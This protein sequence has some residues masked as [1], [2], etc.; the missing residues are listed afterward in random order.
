[1]PRCWLL[2]V[3]ALLPIACSKSGDPASVAETKS[4]DKKDVA[5]SNTPEERFSQ[6]FAQAVTIEIGEDQQVPPD[7]TTAGKPTGPLREAVEKLWPNIALTY[8]NGKLADD[9]RTVTL[10]TAEGNIEITLRPD[11][12]PNHVRN[13]LA[14]VKLGYYDGLRFDRIVRQEG[15]LPDMKKVQVELLKAGCPAG[16]GD[17]GVG[18]LGYHLKPEFSEEKH[19]E[20]TVGMWHDLDPN[21]AGVRFYI[22]LA[23]SPVLDGNFTIFGKVTKGMDVVKKISLGKLLPP[24]QD[25]SRELPQQPVVIKKATSALYIAAN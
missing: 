9:A 13:F 14:L 19:E 3:V 8:N 22:A 10:E 21:T 24:D 1:M 16:T 4:E 12:A 23:P 17:P 15:E 6:T 11:L 7:R 2:F 20:G 25:P 5:D 18:H